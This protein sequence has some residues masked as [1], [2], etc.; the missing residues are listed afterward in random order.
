[1]Q[2]FRY[3]LFLLMAKFIFRRCQHQYIETSKV[4]LINTIRVDLYQTLIER[5][6]AFNLAR[7]GANV[8]Q[9]IDDGCLKHFDSLQE[10]DLL[11][12][13]NTYSSK[14]YRWVRNKFIRYIIQTCINHKNIVTINVSDV[15]HDAGG[16]IE[17]VVLT[18]TQINH[19]ISSCRRF[20]SKDEIL[21]KDNPHEYYLSSIYN[22]KIMHIVALRLLESYRFDKVI[23]SHG[24]Y[25]SWGILHDH[26][27]SMNI[28]T[29]VISKSPYRVNTFYLNRSALQKIHLDYSESEILEKYSWHEIESCV[30]EF[31]KNR[32]T[33]SSPDLHTF[34]NGE[35][36]NEHIS[37]A[38][39]PEIKTILMFPNVVWDGAIEERNI[40]FE[41]IQSWVVETIQHFKGSKDRLIIRFH[42]AEVT[43][44]KGTE[45]LEHL[46][47]QKVED[48]DCYENI[49]LIPSSSKVNSYQL[50]SEAAD[51]V[52]VYDGVIAMEA[53]ELNVPVITAALAR[54]SSAIFSYAP[55][56]KRQYFEFIDNCERISAVFIERQNAIRQSLYAYTFWLNEILQKHFPYSSLDFN[57]IKGMSGRIC[58]FDETYNTDLSKT[59]NCLVDLK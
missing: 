45:S 57:R 59:I 27:S 11:K 12:L 28:E 17:K 30:A 4:Y 56:S 8:Y 48:I 52:L 23:S 50:I 33:F 20:S 15:Y 39:D 22:A 31:F 55:T 49:L 26:F 54:Y 14:L 40:L 1:M 25:V 16:D 37:V 24:I 13:K 41:S 44:F 34:R 51:M 53:T 10:S 38:T 47:R 29:A 43:M 42:P 18:K 7:R 58:E 5:I 2:V 35:D 32:L 3:I 9:L 19:V 46:I 36:F 6:L 21:S